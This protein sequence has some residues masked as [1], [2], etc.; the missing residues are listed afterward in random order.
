LSLEKGAEETTG[1]ECLGVERSHI[2]FPSAGVL[3][4]GGGNTRGRGRGAR[5]GQEHWPQ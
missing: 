1:L 4:A 3:M 2:L 5:G